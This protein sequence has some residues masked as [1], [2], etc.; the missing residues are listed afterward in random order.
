MKLTKSEFTQL[1]SGIVS[2]LS[3]DK[4]DQWHDVRD[5][6]NLDCEDILSLVDEYFEGVDC[7]DNDRLTEENK[8]LLDN[9]ADL[10]EFIKLTLIRGIEKDEELK[11]L[12]EINEQLSKELAESVNFINDMGDKMGNLASRG[13]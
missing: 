6:E 13:K 7:D 8:N 1:V 9:R 5:Y 10:V 11:N 4:S 2:G 12:K 3:I